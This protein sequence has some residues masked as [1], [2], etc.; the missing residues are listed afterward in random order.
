MVWYSHLVY[1]VHSLIHLVDDVKLY[2]PLDSF[3]AFP[4][5]SYMSKVKKMIRRN[6]NALPQIFNRIQEMYQ[7]NF[8]PLSKSNEIVLKNNVKTAKHTTK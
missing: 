2:G 6:N 4:F 3:S 5:E 8:D 1:N 7:L